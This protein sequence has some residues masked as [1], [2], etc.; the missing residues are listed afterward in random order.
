M[1]GYNNTNTKVLAEH[2]QGRNTRML[3]LHTCNDG[4]LEYVIGSYF[5]EEWGEGNVVDYSWDWGHYFGDV[6][7][8]VD[9]WKQEVL[10]A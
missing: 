9:Y 6:V 1:S 4:R 10:G 7:S 5:T 8:A 3:L 2:P